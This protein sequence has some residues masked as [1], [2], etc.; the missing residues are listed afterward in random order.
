MGLDSR[1]VVALAVPIGL[2]LAYGAARLFTQAFGELRDG[3]FIVP[4]QHAIRTLALQTFRHLHGLSIRFHL[5]RQTGGLTTAINRGAK[6]IEF[7]LRF[8]LLN[9]VPTFIEILLVCAFFFW[10]FGPFYAVVTFVTLVG[11]I[12]Y[13]IAV[14]EWRLKF[15]KAM[16]ES[17]EAANTKAIDSLLNFETVKYFSNERHEADRYDRALKGYQSAAIT[18]QY[19]LTLLNIGQGVIIS[20]GM[21]ALMWMAAAQVVADQGNP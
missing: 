8:M 5:N 1:E 7:L 14:T 4:T 10:A 17:D 16:N 12:W 18:S 3:L 20:I 19:S 15:R 6:G 2:I 9:F 21:I 13:T 11:Y